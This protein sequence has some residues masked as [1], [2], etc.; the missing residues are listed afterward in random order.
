MTTGEGGREWFKGSG[1]GLA[2]DN[3]TSTEEFAANPFQE[4]SAASL[5]IAGVLPPTDTVSEF[6]NSVWANT[7][8]QALLGEL[9]AAG[10]LEVMNQSLNGTE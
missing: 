8:Q 4:I 9:D 5:E 1:K 10:A 6:I 2:T 7:N 3:V